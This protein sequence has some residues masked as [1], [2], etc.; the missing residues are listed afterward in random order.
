MQFMIPYRVQTAPLSR[1]FDT[2]AD[3]LQQ[4]RQALIFDFDGQTL[5]NDDTAE[6]LD[7]EDMNY[8]DVRIRS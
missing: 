2:F 7:I 5:Q 4:D 3:W 8:I 1:A 6:S